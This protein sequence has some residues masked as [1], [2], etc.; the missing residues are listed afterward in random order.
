MSRKFGVVFDDHVAEE[1]EESLEYG[2]SRSARI[3]ELA[4]IGLEVE[5]Q[6]D[7]TDASYRNVHE[8]RAIVRQAFD[9]SQHSVSNEDADSDLD[10]DRR[11][12]PEA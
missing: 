10:T 7:E 11:P 3:Q 2:D 5:R 9:E 1:V 6:I 12:E 8:L 4:E